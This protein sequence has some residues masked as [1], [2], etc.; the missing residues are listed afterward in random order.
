[1][2]LSFTLSLLSQTLKISLLVLPEQCK[3][4]PCAASFLI[5]QLESFEVNLLST[6]SAEMM[7]QCAHSCS[8]PRNPSIH[9]ASKLITS[10]RESFSSLLSE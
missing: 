7:A 6:S 3:L 5:M 1:M 9:Q 2:F 8:S 4:L 10:G